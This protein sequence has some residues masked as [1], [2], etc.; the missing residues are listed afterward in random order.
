MLIRR[1]TEFFFENRIKCKIKS[2]Q[3][4]SW[5]DSMSHKMEFSLSPLFAAKVGF[6]QIPKRIRP[7]AYAHGNVV[8]LM[9]LFTMTS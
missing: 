6:L 4:Q 8:L 2:L 5:N 3:I 1:T 9:I 7:T